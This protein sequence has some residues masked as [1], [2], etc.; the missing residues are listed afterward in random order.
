M[1]STCATTLSCCGG[2]V[3]RFAV[4]V[5]VAGSQLASAA[6]VLTRARGDAAQH[7]GNASYSACAQRGVAFKPRKGDALLFYSLTPD[8]QLDPQSLHGCAA[9]ST[10][11]P[12]LAAGGRPAHGLPMSKWISL[13][14]LCALPGT[15]SV[16]RNR[17]SGFGCMFPCGSATW[18]L[19]FCALGALR[20]SRF[21]QGLPRHQ[22]QQVVR[23]KVDAREGVC[24]TRGQRQ[25]VMG[26]LGPVYASRLHAMGTY[27][28]SDLIDNE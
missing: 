27:P 26:R 12:A 7:D 11:C 20:G 17:G 6:W 14:C 28:A 16:V 22:G 13:R 9:A 1:P 25:S 23:H 8:G 21:V 4:L 10:A 5:M 15:H 2:Y 3:Q 19:V 18:T 24:R